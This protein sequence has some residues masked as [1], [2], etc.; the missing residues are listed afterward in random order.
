M[1]LAGAL[2]VLRA[3]FL[4]AGAGAG[5]A[6]ATVTAV[7]VAPTVLRAIVIVER[8]SFFPE[9]ASLTSPPTGSSFSVIARIALFHLAREAMMVL[10]WGPN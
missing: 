3:A 9:L 1:T 8:I 2:A 6:T 4:G 7:C 10:E 5:A